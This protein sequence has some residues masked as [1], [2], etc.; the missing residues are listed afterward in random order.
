MSLKLRF[1]I[2]IITLAVA[3]TLIVGWTRVR[4]VADELEAIGV[5]PVLSGR[6]LTQMEES[7][8]ALA[9]ILAIFSSFFAFMLYRSFAEPLVSLV[10]SMRNIRERFLGLSAP[11]IS[12][13]PS[14]EIAE[15]E[16]TFNDMSGRMERYVEE[17]EEADRA[18]DNFLAILGHEL[19]NPL[20]PIVTSLELVRLRGL[21][22]PEIDRSFRIIDRQIGHMQKL[23]DYLLDVSRLKRG[24]VVLEKRRIELGHTVEESKEDVM[25]FIT[26]KKQRIEF[27]PSEIPL[28]IDGDRLRLTQ[29]FVNLLKNA[30]EHTPIG[31]TVWL[32]CN[33]ENGMAKV[34][35]CDHGTGIAPEDLPQM[36]TLFARGVSAKQ[37][38][39]GIG[40]GLYLVKSFIDMHGGSVEAKSEGLGKGAEFIV[41][42]PLLK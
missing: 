15:L 19:R 26:Q 30:S 24:K 28:F 6:I 7:S 42:L 35:V 34:S 36:F 8:L 11:V 25:P 33:A 5:D 39:A 12:N 9:L 31:G 14:N 37:K 3:P 20:A 13:A 23:L 40:V 4:Y 1:F 41:R 38:P 27:I 17:L 18:K 21:H 29:V 16:Q 22:D 32:R 2:F 10:E